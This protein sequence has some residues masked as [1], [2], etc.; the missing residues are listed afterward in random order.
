MNRRPRRHAFT[1]IELLVV[2][3]IIAVLLG[4]L[5]P[6][7]GKAREQARRTNC[8]SN[9]RSLGQSLFAYAN[10]N[11][12]RLPNGNAPLVTV[13]YA[14]A[15][16][17]M[18]DFNRDWVKEPRVFWCPS[19]RDPPPKEILTADPLLP[20]S[21]RTSYEFYSLYWPPED[22]PV[23]S[24]FKGRA[25]LAWDLD[26][27]EPTSPIQNHGNKGGHVVYAD[28]HAEWQNAPRWDGPNWAYP[29]AEFYVFR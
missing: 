28:G 23:L 1:L 21:A 17:V 16:R 10:A 22:G 12:D 3:G 6:S 2:I 29:A 25:P 5:L 26:G 8:L 14:G 15:N 27:A 11:R 13:D 19:D 20:D 24:R 18:T 7:L 9:L 4:I